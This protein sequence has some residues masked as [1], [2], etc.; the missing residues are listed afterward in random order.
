MLEAQ[1][2]ALNTTQNILL[3]CKEIAIQAANETIPAD[4]RASMSRE[5]FQ[6][7]DQLIGVINTRVQGSYIYGGGL[8][9]QPPFALGT[10]Y[11]EPAGS[12]DISIEARERYV[13]AG[14]D[15]SVDAA[16][17]TF[18]LPE[19][20][21]GLT[22]QI[23]ITDSEQVRITS[24]AEVFRD[25]VT[26]IEFL[27]R[28]LAG[29]ETGNMDPVDDPT[30]IPP[31]VNDWIAPGANNAYAT[32]HLVPDGS[33]VDWSVV[34]PNDTDGVYDIQTAAILRAVDL[35][36]ESSVNDVDVERTSVG[37]RMARMSQSR[38]MLDVL[39]LDSEK[40]RAS[41]QDA[42]IFEAA[43]KLS[44]MEVSLQALLSTGARISSLSLL[45]YI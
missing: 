32:S 30:A 44:S 37:A 40:A 13:W 17:P 28:A 2:T 20:G 27:G 25:A 34:Y 38:D 41:I 29:V 11:A 31:I 18:S 39:I 6:L 4:V 12:D 14:D 10:E 15:S 1:E 7:R 9:D 5:V 43:S 23:Q 33:G 36:T 24:S 19:P 35:I 16:H 26:S 42:D 3:R 22:R 45:N 8:D 21:I